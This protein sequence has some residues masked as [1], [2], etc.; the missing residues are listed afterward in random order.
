MGISQGVIRA[1]QLLLTNTKARVNDKEIDIKIGV[2][3][4]GVL[5]PQLFTLFINDLIQI[6]CSDEKFFKATALA[7]ADDVVIVTQ[8]IL[9]VHK[10]IKKLTDWCM[11]N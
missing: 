10:I 6:L 9:S 8:G 2:M 4:G 5:S 3:Q 7:F 11:I 1:I